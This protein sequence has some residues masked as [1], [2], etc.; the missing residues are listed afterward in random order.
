[1]GT[2]LIATVDFGS[3][4]IS[5][6]LGKIED[7]FLD[8]I[9][10][11]SEQSEGIEKGLIT[12][13]GKCSEV[14]K[15]L[16][17]ELQSLSEMKITQIYAG[18]SSRNIRLSDGFAGVT[19]KGD[20]VTGNDIKDVMNIAYRKA[21]LSE[22][23]EVVDIIINFYKLD[24]KIIY[25]NVLG[26]FGNRLEIDF[27]ILIGTKQEIEKFKQVIKESGYQCGGLILNSIA[28]KNIFINGKSALGVRAI[29]DIGAGT[30]DYAIYSNGVLKYIN[31]R[32]IGGKNIST[33]ISI[34]GEYPISVAD[35]IKKNYSE[36]YESEY[37]ASK[38]PDVISVGLEKVSKELFYEV[39]RTR[40]E[41]IIKYVN[42]DL[43]N[44]SFYGG[45][46]SIII[47]GDGIVYFE[48]INNTIQSQITKKVI[49]ADNKYLGMKKTSNITS[50]ALL[51]EVYNRYNLLSDSNPNIKKHSVEYKNSKEEDFEEDYEEEDF[52]ENGI[53]DR[54]KNFL[55][56]IF[57]GRN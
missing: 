57:K 4:K 39:A 50:L 54:I 48:N 5:A 8:I 47:Y 34:C 23:E 7:D 3:D 56:G 1:M 21:E 41:E 15:K 44:T 29:V 42:M 17:S 43:K 46:C 19:I 40:L 10:S 33:D 30:T 6:S 51:Q 36:F 53:I 2:H 28:G 22:G 24:N 27:S 49:I 16:F 25:E 14:V 38:T 12:D 26:E 31:C 55:V 52:K 9:G 11:K 32:P 20:Y 13:V 35:Q 45:L 37:L 18:I